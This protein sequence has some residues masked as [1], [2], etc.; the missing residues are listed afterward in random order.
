M[1]IDTTQNLM[2]IDGLKVIQ[3]VDGDTAPE[4]GETQTVYIERAGIDTTF[5]RVAVEVLLATNADKPDSGSTKLKKFVLAERIQTMD[6]VDLANNEVQLIQSACDIFSNI[7]ICGR[8]T[9]ILD[10][11]GYT[12]MQQGKEVESETKSPVK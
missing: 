1:K 10:P 12:K 5:R 2:S 3:T 11:E 7:L 9:E 6:Q 8:M 4:E